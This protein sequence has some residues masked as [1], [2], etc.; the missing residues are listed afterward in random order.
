MSFDELD[1][2]GVGVS[3]TLWDLTAD[4]KKLSFSNPNNDTHSNSLNRGKC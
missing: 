1:Q 4:S 3:T 2:R